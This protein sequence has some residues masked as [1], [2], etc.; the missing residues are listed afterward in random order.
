MVGVCCISRTRNEN[1]TSSLQTQKKFRSHVAV[2][3]VL[4]LSPSRPLRPP[5]T[6]RGSFLVFESMT[7][8]S[9]SLGLLA[10]RPKKGE[11]PTPS[12]ISPQ[13]A[14]LAQGSKVGI[15]RR[16]RNF[17][18]SPVLIQTFQ[19]VWIRLE[20]CACRTEASIQ[21]MPCIKRHS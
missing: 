17:G 4:A 9:Q 15:E 3:I 8:K 13:A 10:A 5:R 12:Q 6:H 11:G 2:T 16:I 1:Q 7:T 18:F 20:V 19:K 14:S 21:A